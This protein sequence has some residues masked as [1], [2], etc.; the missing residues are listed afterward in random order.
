[1]SPPFDYQLEQLP[2]DVRV[3]DAPPA[4]PSTPTIAAPPPTTPN[5]YAADGAGMLSR[6][7]AGV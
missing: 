3:G 5:I 6:Q 7:V 2:L 4:P 1:M